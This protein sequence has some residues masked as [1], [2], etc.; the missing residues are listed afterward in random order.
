MKAIPYGRQD[1]RP[2]DIDAVVSALQSD[3]LTQGPTIDAFE[4][5]FATYIGS[6]YAVAVANGTA[7]LHLAVLALGL[8]PEEYVITSPITFAASGN[9]ALY[10]GAS[11][12]FAETDDFG[13]VRPE[14][15]QALFEQHGNK[16]K[17]VIPVDFAG[18]PAD[19]PAI[20]KTADA[21]GAW[22]LEDSCHA[23][24][25]ERKGP[26]GFRCGDGSLADAAIFSF[27]P[28]KHIACGE[29][30]MITT[31]K[32]EIYERLLTLRTHGITRDPQRFSNPANLADSSLNPT[33]TYPLWYM[34]MQE[35]G[36][37]YRITE[38]QAALGL[39]QLKR[40]EE[41]LQRRKEIAR[42]YHAAL[43]GVGDLKLPHADSETETDDHAWHLY[44][45]RTQHRKALYDFLRSHQIFAQV[46]YFPLHLMPYYRN[47]FGYNA[48][49]CPE[50]EQFYSEC[51]SIPMYPSLS[52]DDLH[53]V[54]DRVTAFFA[55]NSMV[56]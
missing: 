20:K 27:H 12:L 39:S 52:N 14:S 22:V 34:E 29:G 26:N 6:K 30:G 3:Y 50:A 42:F 46:H 8:G 40:A 55:Q 1:I 23:P 25:A 47:A 48:G 36:Y 15:V 54:V 43:S 33:D 56:S 5:A 7:A 28:V 41:G 24:G 35:L 53:Y 18:R 13:T 21:Y 37:N 38:M 16:I 31:S 44:V 11:V 19:L 17:G 45:V 4:K 9:C 2:E 51:L 10:A 49:L 32:K